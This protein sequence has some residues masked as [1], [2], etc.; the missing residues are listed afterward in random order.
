MEFKALRVPSLTKDVAEN[1]E[2][3]LD[4]LPG[5]RKFEVTLDTQELY[6]VFDENQVG[7]QTLAEEMAKVGCSL[8]HIDAALLL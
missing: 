6:I 5:V 3:L 8:R 4:N 1:L 2:Q 7:F